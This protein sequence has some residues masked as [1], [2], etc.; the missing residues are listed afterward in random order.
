MTPLL[1]DLDLTQINLTQ[2]SIA[3]LRCSWSL[4]R[5]PNCQP[6]EL[7]AIRQPRMGYRSAPEVILEF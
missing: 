5:L 7:T 4:S 3:V 6:C 1:Y 2:G